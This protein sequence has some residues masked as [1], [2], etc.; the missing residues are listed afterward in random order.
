MSTI[1]IENINSAGIASEMRR[2]GTTKAELIGIGEWEN[3]NP[4][5]RC[6][7]YRIIDPSTGFDFR[8]ANTNGDPVWEEE[9][10]GAFAEL[11]ESC[12]VKL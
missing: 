5:T 8:V 2:I 12:G 6:E 9:D 1:N 4:N 3:G 10:H 7:F 11:A